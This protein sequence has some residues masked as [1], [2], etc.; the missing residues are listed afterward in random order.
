MI[1]KEIELFKEI[2]KGIEF[3]C[4]K[5]GSC[6]R[7]FQEGEVYLYMD[8]IKRLA[9]HLNL[10]GLEGLGKFVKLYIKIIPQSFYWKEPGKSRGKTYKF[11]TLGF[12]FT[13]SDEHCHFLKENKC[14]VHEKRPFQC[15]CFPWWQMLVS[16]KSKNNFD[17]YAKKCK[18]LGL[19]KGKFHSAKTILK[20]AKKEYEIERDYFLEM[21]KY[22][23]DISKIYPFIPKELLENN[24]N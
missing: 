9:A 3:S 13:G 5:C 7:G 19:L 2:S 8:D 11:K 6:C 15:R 20:W 24:E 4:Q 10:K 21:K 16:K 14:S 1:T 22:N 12:K 17:D 18:G 23:F